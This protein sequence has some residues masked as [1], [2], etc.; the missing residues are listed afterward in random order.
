MSL[1]K[2]EKFTSHLFSNILEKK[3]IWNDQ[4]FNQHSR[5]DTLN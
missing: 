3:S 2:E 4:I 1:E 5:S